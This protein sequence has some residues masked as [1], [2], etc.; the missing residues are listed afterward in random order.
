[1]IARRRSF[2]V[3]AIWLGVL[4]LAAWSIARVPLLTDMSVFLPQRPT[5]EQRLLVE[6]LTQGPVA[7]ML[8]LGVDGLNAE[9]RG[10][11]SRAFG[12]A[13]RASGQFDAV[14]NGDAEALRADQRLLFERRYALSSRV[15]AG[16]FEVDALRVSLARTVELLSGSAG[17]FAKDLLLRDPTGE[18]TGLVER[19]RAEQAPRLADGVWVSADGRRAML[20]A[21]TRAD[22]GDLDGQQR[23]LEAVDAAFERARAEAGPEGARAVL[24]ASGPGRF[25]VASRDAIRTDVTRLSLIGAAL[26]LGLLGWAFRSPGAL[27]LALMPIVSAVAVATA[28]VAWGFGAVHGLTVGFGTTLIGEAVDYALYH[29][30]RSAST[31]P[32][33]EGAFW[34][35]IRLGVL[36]SVAGFGALLFSGF[37]GLAQLSVF[38]IA[39]LLTAVV[40]TRWVLPVLTPSGFRPRPL[41][42]LDARVAR[43]FALLRRWRWPLAALVGVALALASARSERLW[44]PDIAS[45]NPV[46]RAAQRLDQELREALGAPDARVMVVVR[47]ADQASALSAAWALHPRFEQWVREGRIAAYESPAALLP[48]PEA[49]RER[50]GALPEPAVLRERLAR[51]ADGLPIRADRLEG[52]I[53][54]VARAREQAPV[55]LTDFDGTQLGVRLR[56]QLTR[57]ADG[58]AAIVALRAPRGASLDAGALRAELPGQPDAMPAMLD[59]KAETDRLYAGYLREAMSLSVGGAFAVLG[60]LAWRL[61]SARALA[62][63]AAPLLGAVVL[64]IGVFAAADRPMNLLHLIGLLLVVAIGS[65]YALFLHSLREGP[66]SGAGD[67]M[68]GDGASARADGGA[69]GTL[70][71]LALANVTTLAGFAVLAFSSVPLLQA[72]GVTVGLGCVAALLLAAAWVRP[73]GERRE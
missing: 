8:L 37:P 65:N 51:A 59:L 47:G 26:I 27:L 56:A 71:A 5:P 13:L 43:G 30:V 22:G 23:A 12:A 69:G 40:V 24:E 35:T 46:S 31:S 45:L 50:L 9:T 18:L 7:R 58:W 38:S 41:D 67:D 42:A 64:V 39:G 3:L 66:L 57:H 60:L 72:L 68:P 1:M 25:A 53:A 4:L 29:L 34:A 10:G 6:T 28:A 54:D 52:F 61:R 36:T 73:R 32:A 70:A 33:P 20:L 2:G 14:N 55:T 62:A 44:D 21:L 49:Q 19:L 48:P 63:V 16:R 15:D 11:F 17:L